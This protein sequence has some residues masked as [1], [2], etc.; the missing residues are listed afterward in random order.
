MNK[1]KIKTNKNH[2]ITLIALIITVIVLLILAGTAISIAVNGGDLFGKSQNAVTEYNTKV[3]QEETA[4]KDAFT[5]L[6]DMDPKPV[7]VST[8]YPAGWND[9]SQLSGVATSGSRT[10][11][12]PDGFAVSGVEGENVIQNGLVIYQ[13]NSSTNASA[14]ALTKVETEEE[15]ELA[16]N[17]LNQFVWIP[18]DDINQM[19]MCKDNNKVENANGNKICNLVRQSNGSLKCMTHHAND[20]GTELCGRLYGTGATTNS[21]GT[22]SATNPYIYQTSMDF[23]KR[24]QIWEV[25]ESNG[26][27]T[28]GWREPDTTTDPTNG[29]SSANGLAGVKSILNNT[30]DTSY[31][32]VATAWEKELKDNFKAMAESVAK[33]GGFYVARYEA[34]FD[35]SSYT[36]KRGQTVMNAQTATAAPN[37]GADMWYG[38]YK[39]L[40][41]KKGGATSTM[42]WGCQYDQIIN[43]I[44]AQ[45]QIGHPDRY[46]W[47]STTTG[48]TSGY[49]P[50]GNTKLL[51][52]MKNIYDLE[53]NYFE[54]T[55]Q[56]SSALG[57]T[58]RGGNCSSV[59]LSSF[60]P[61]S[62]RGNSYPTNTIAYSGSRSALYM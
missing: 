47:S 11:P 30:T 62:S 50:T 56:A 5:I 41:G 34:G 21:T 4:I 59:A 13:L 27:T 36:S 20:N 37:K 38:L 29:D 52:I 39:H 53:G 33:Y 28:Y 1:K 44:G 19:V 8:N 55:A 3:S 26:T 24:D 23:S 43:F 57:R 22:R 7:T 18:V 10:V 14:N 16:I 25:T 46:L 48:T 2:G 17:N 12:I 15:H 51:D 49:E 35:S 61:A 54:W 40:K 45:A 6:T 31:D 60:R 42:I 58:G 32:A 9:K